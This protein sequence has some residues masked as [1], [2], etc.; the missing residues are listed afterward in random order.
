LLFRTFDRTSDQD[1]PAP[2]RAPAAAAPRTLIAGGL[3]GG[4]ATVAG[5]APEIPAEVA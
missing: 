2:P 3:G 5:S 1:A 4:G